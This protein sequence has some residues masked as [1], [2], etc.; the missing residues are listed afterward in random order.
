MRIEK[1]SG[2]MR[3][4]DFAA[5]PAG[6]DVIDISAFYS[7]FNDLVAHMRQVGNNVDIALGHNDQL[8]LENVLL[9]ALDAGDFQFNPA[10]LGSY[11]ASSFV[12]SGSLPG[13]TLPADAGGTDVGWMSQHVVP[14]SV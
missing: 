8:V 10:L 6:G 11:M 5:G 14:H 7:N 3:I 4:A 13:G 1:G 12:A 9:G 2:S